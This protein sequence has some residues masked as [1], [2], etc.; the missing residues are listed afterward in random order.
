MQTE[1]AQMAVVG[2]TTRIDV[3]DLLEKRVRSRCSQ[4]QLLLPALTGADDCSRVLGAA[5]SLPSLLTYSSAF[6][7]KAKPFHTAWSANSAAVC[8]SLA[9]E[10][11]QLTR[12]LSMGVTAG[13]LQTAVRL[14]LL[15]LSE[16]QPLVTVEKLET[17][18]RTLVLPRPE[19]ILVECSYVE[20]LLLLCLR[21]LEGS[22]LRRRLVPLLCSHLY[23]KRSDLGVSCCA[24]SSEPALPPS[25]TPRSSSCPWLTS[26]R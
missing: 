16:Q 6:A 26:R 17:A 3:A 19:T 14:A 2:L 10:A 20:L 9:T 21:L 22:Y 15:E 4:R 13:Q 18:L 8:A 11:P 24:C 5:L 25:C 12:R 7:A 1:D 23:S